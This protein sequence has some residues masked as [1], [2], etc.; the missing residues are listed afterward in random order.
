MPHDH[1]IKSPPLRGG[2]AGQ[3]GSF[4]DGCW[5]IADPHRSG[6][7]GV[8]RAATASDPTDPK[9]T[10]RVRGSLS[11][12]KIV[13]SSLLPC[14][15]KGKPREVFGVDE[16]R[17]ALADEFAG[18]PDQD[19]ILEQFDRRRLMSLPAQ[20]PVITEAEAAWQAAVEIRVQFGGT[21]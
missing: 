8:G 14:E 5:E 19:R 1:Q 21:A 4:L 10:R 20:Y 13:V 11:P 7:A 12:I 3:V 6:Q 2:A 9:A 15:P 16:L 17:S 18:H